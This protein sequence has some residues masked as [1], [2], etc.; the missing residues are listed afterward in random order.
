MLE[1]LRIFWFQLVSVR[2]FCVCWAECYVG[3]S[4]NSD[5]YIFCYCDFIF[6]LFKYEK[7]INLDILDG[8]NRV[9]SDLPLQVSNNTGFS[10]AS[11]LKL[12]NKKYIRV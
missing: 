6:V 9:E 8:L 1:R 5:P 10:L 2:R 3:Q 11:P 7:I 12:Q 4:S